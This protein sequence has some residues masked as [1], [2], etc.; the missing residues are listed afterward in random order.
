LLP[1]KVRVAVR[2]GGDRDQ[3]RP[4]SIL[5]SVRRAFIASLASQAKIQLQVAS[6]A[7]MPA[8]RM[9]SPQRFV[10]SFSQVAIV[11]GLL[12]DFA[13]LF[14]DLGLE[15]WC[16]QNLLISALSR[17]ITAGGVP[18]ATTILARC[19][20]AAG[21]LGFSKSADRSGGDALPPVTARPTSCL[22]LTNGRLST[23]H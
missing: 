8:S 21:Q 14:G 1:D 2:D 4:K 5:K 22:L 17:A 18:L 9:M 20:T 10:E 13:A 3:N 15:F 16:L 6:F 19:R 11:A 7:L 12:A 23:H